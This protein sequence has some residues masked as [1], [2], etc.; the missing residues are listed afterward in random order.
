[1]TEDSSKER[2]L[3]RKAYKLGYEVGYYGHMETLSWVSEEKRRLIEEAISHGIDVNVIVRAYN[4]G[5][6]RGAEEKRKKIQE[7]LSKKSLLERLREE[8]KEI[9]TV[10]DALSE[11]QIHAKPRIIRPPLLLQPISILAKAHLMILG[12]RF[13]TSRRRRRRRLFR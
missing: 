4:L 5:K 1:M 9:Y 2:E 12:P 8:F 10:S 7:E 3:V 13:L 11:P 6:K